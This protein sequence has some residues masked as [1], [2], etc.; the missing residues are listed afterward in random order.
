MI[1]HNDEPVLRVGMRVAV[2]RGR[3][4]YVGVIIRFEGEH[5]LVRAKYEEATDRILVAHR[6]DIRILNVNVMPP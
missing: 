5:V 2:R 1:E 4:E 3:D 6:D